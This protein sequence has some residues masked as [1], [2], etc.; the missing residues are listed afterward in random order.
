M[1]A[2]DCQLHSQSVSQS[3]ENLLN[4]NFLKFNSNLMQSLELI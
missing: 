4:K 3:V 1:K 2:S